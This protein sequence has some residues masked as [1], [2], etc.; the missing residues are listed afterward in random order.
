MPEIPIREAAY[1][2]LAAALAGLSIDGEAMAVERNRIADVDDAARPL[3]VLIDGD[4]ES[5]GGS[6]LEA[7]YVLRAIAAGYL[8]GVDDA[9]LARRVNEWHARV[10]RAVMRPGGAS[11]V[12]DILLGDGLTAVRV[13]EGAFATEPATVVQSEAPTA[14]CTLELRLIVHAPWGNPFI[15]V[16]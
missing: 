13:E 8:G 12:A 4:Q 15:T 11:Q 6:T 10:V 5:E 2:A 1:A 7:R 9:Q 14:A 16:P 3:L